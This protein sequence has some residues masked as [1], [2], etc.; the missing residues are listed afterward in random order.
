MTNKKQ[1]NIKVHNNVSNPKSIHGI[2]PYRGKISAI[3][4]RDVI[5][6]LDSGK[7]LLDPFCGSGTILYEAAQKNIKSIGF[8]TNPIAVW[9]SKG[10]LSLAKGSI[11]QYIEEVEDLIKIAKAS[12][13]KSMPEESLKHFHVD[14][15]DEI[16]RLTRLIDTMSDYVK[17]CF[18]GSIALSA[19]GC[20]HYKWTSSTVGKDIVPKNY[21][22]FYDKFL[23]KTKKHFYPISNN[24]DH[25]VFQKDS[26]KLSRYIKPGTI[27]YVFTSPP[28]FDAL[29]Y[30]AYYAKII[31]NILEL[32]RSAIREDIIQTTKA[33]KDDMKLVLE[34]IVKVTHD[35]SLIIFVV[36]DKKL[37]GETINGGVFFSDLLH[38]QPSEII[39]RTYSGS[40][41]Q[42]F[43]SL[44]KTVRKEQIVVW[45]RRDW[46]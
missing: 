25:K 15:A 37:K 44:N 16:M 43:D 12:D 13:A 22:N 40:S 34:E 2:Y 29:D 27:D 26:R 11:N 4:A 36:G 3:D 21:I 39:E 41:S 23:Q 6:G 8:D 42:I 14:T 45:D 28:Y 7:T 18:F 46:K 19:R 35:K 1:I 20:N 17:A 5:A 31:Y 32:D 24:L 30:T 9:L 38:H 10:K 33:Y